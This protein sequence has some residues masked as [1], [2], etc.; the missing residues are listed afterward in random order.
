MLGPRSLEMDGMGQSQKV[1]LGGSSVLPFWEGV[2]GKAIG[3]GFSHSSAREETV[4][5]ETPL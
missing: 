3:F 2:E 4:A 5:I 1:L